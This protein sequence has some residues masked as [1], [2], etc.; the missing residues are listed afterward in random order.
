M[1]DTRIDLSQLDESRTVPSTPQ[2]QN[3]PQQTV[4][5]SS[6]STPATTSVIPSESLADE[7]VAGTSDGNLP[8]VVVTD[9]SHEGLW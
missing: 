7:T 5:E 4:G 1:D 6:E 8:E 2:Q 9:M 3:S